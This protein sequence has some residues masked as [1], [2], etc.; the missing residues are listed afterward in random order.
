MQLRC[1]HCRSLV[2]V[3][4][5]MR[6]YFGMP[7]A[8]HLCQRRFV[9]PPQSPLHDAALPADSVRPLDRSISA[10]RCF[11][12][13]RCPHCRHQLRVPGMNQ[14]TMRIEL[15]CPYCETKLAIGGPAQAGTKSH[16]HSTHHRASCGRRRA[17]AGPDGVDRPPEFSGVTFFAGM[18]TGP[19]AP[20]GQLNSLGPPST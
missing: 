2:G 15:S 17:V 10:I 20:R 6:C 14:P 4:D 5:G 16:H 9:V 3:P 7:V 1:P 8:C 19:S 18:E 13:H 11:H 12:E